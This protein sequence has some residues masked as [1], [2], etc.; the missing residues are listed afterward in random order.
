MHSGSVT[1]TLPVVG[2]PLARAPCVL[3]AL[4]TSIG[5]EIYA[6]GG[7]DGRSRMKSAE[8]YDPQ[9]NQWHIIPS[10]NRAR[11]DASAAALN[12]RVSTSS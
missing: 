3:V 1:L 4:H 8:T 2:V 11:S 12:G 7:F 5:G 9:K 10:M 6:V